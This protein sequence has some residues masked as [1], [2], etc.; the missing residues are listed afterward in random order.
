MFVRRAAQTFRHPCRHLCTADAERALLKRRQ[1]ECIPALKEDRPVKEVEDVKECFSVVHSQFAPWDSRYLE[2]KVATVGECR[3]ASLA[4]QHAMS[5]CCDSDGIGRLF[6]PHVPEAAPFLGHDGHSLFTTLRDR[7]RQ[8][9]CAQ[10]GEVEEANSLISWITGSSARVPNDDE[11]PLRSFDSS[12]DPLDGTYAP[13][14][15]QAN[16]PAYD[17]SA[18]LYLTTHG[19][20]FTGG[21]FAFKMSI[22]IYSSGLLPAGCLPSPQALRICTR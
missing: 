19:K 22:V 17:I 8:R 16:Q 7:V 6:P 2:D 12:A 18:L 4:A 15:D 11:R 13:H 20:D 9:V 21:H 3:R 10:Y 14:V 5:M 1:L